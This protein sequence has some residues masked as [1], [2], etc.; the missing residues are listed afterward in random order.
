MGAAGYMTTN[1]NYLGKQ[2]SL[3][4]DCLF[5]CAVIAY[6]Y[7]RSLIKLVLRVVNYVTNGYIYIYHTGFEIPVRQNPGLLLC[8]ASLT[9]PQ[10]VLF[11][12]SISMRYQHRRN[13]F[14]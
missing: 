9:E 10:P 4:M 3:F 11:F 5:P 6:F 1:R 12:Q 7:K 14:N 2:K 13:Y 8:E